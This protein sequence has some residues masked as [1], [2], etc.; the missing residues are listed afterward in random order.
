MISHLDH[1]VITT[2][3]E[4]ACVDFY[5]RVLGM[6]LHTFMAGKPPG[7]RKSLHFGPQKINIHVAGAE[8]DP[9]AHRPTVGSQDLCFMLAVPLDAM[10][11]HLNKEQWPIMLG[12]VP[13]TGATGMI[14]SVYVRDPD[15][16]LIELCEATPQTPQ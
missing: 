3:D 1:L 12:P 5:T 10:I 2:G 16:N 7:A 9:K 11:D 15:Q 6:S 8:F 4:D 13:R 14:R